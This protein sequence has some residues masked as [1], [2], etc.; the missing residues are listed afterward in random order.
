MGT[1]YTL[2]YGVPKMKHIVITSIFPAT[3][4]VQLFSKVPGHR[5]IVVGDKKSPRDWSCPNVDFLEVSAHAT[6]APAFEQELPFNHYCRKMIGYLHAIELGANVIID[7]DDDNIPK[8]T[9]N[10]PEFDGNFDTTAT[11]LG[12]VN[13]YN[14]YTEQHIWPRGFPL[15][16][17]LSPASTV[18]RES[19]VKSSRK[20]GIWQGLADID[21]DV[22]AIYRLTIGKDC[23]FN[24]GAPM[25]LA[26]GTLCPFNSQNTAI[27][28]ELFSLLYLP[29]FVT[30][31][32]TDILRGLVAQPILWAAGYDLGFCQATVTQLR[33]EH[34]YLKD[35][36]S[37]IPCYLLPDKI[38]SIVSGCV[39]S[40]ASVAANLF[41]AYSALHDNSIVEER[42]LDLLGLWLKY[43]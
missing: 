9:W 14:N 36:E 26:P 23:I 27:R 31:R 24:E 1:V 17:V 30:F 6:I 22:D 28:S 15:K 32:F 41:A 25:V 13:V 38:I 43:F 33:N 4:A 7:T 35:F 8:S 12:F 2:D 39:K 18:P 21:P 3:E 42:E 20:I 16:K 40:E 19:M 37:E 5:L 34:D 10:F 11:N 29:A